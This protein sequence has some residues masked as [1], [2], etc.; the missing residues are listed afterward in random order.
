MLKAAS[1]PVDEKQDSF[2]LNTDLDG[3]TIVGKLHSVAQRALKIYARL[4]HGPLKLFEIDILIMEFPLQERNRIALLVMNE[5][6]VHLPSD[7]PN[8]N[9]L[10]PVL[11]SFLIVA[12]DLFT[13]QMCQLFVHQTD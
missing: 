4:T 1:V 2:P 11:L 7:L 6:N 9:A 12:R 10:A 3:V 5:L 13:F 8:D